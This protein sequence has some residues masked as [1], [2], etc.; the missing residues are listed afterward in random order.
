MRRFFAAPS[1]IKGTT[2]VFTADQSHHIRNVLRLYEGEVT[3]FD[4]AGRAFVVRLEPG[5]TLP[6]T[7]TVTETIEEPEPRI[8]IALIQALPKKGKMDFVVGKASELGASY[9]QPLI[10]ERVTGLPA[11]ET[12]ERYL[13]RWRKIAVESARQSGRFRI[14][15]VRPPSDFEAVLKLGPGV[16]GLIFHPEGRNLKEALAAETN[17]ESAPREIRIVIGPE[18]GFTRGELDS[19][20]ASGY[21]IVSLKRRTLRTE[22]AGPAILAI[23]GFH[24]GLI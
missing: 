15:E 20:S 19:A 11:R 12:F 1:Q 16:T 8:S 5:R 22:T 9:I 10:T 21:E 24:Y 17:D 14:M 2:V 23:L 6:V 18:G 3:A 4:G 7:G 13:L